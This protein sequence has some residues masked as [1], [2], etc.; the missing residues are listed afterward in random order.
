MQTREIFVRCENNDRL[1]SMHTSDHRRSVTQ[2]HTWFHQSTRS[3][4][5]DTE[6]EK[7]DDE[8]LRFVSE[9]FHVW[10]DEGTHEPIRLEKGL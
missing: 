5:R 10:R 8:N 7:E 9:G 3:L 6:E 4:T 1:G 2:R